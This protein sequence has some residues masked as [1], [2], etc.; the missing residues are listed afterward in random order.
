MKPHIAYKPIL[1][2]A[3]IL[4]LVLLQGLP[5]YTPSFISTSYLGVPGTVWAT[6]FWFITMVVLSW[7]FGKNNTDYL[8]EDE[9]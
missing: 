6:S 2:T 3:L 9:A 4:P 5:Q 8:N 1:I 7:Y